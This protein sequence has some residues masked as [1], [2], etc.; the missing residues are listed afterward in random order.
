MG[1]FRER[2][3]KWY[4][5]KGYRMEWR[6]DEMV[7]RCPV[8]VR[9]LVYFFFSPCAYYREVGYDFGDAFES[10]WLDASQISVGTLRIADEDTEV[11]V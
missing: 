5:R 11:S 3:T 7:F 1:N 9:P 4:Y 6:T 2:F 10:V 8:W